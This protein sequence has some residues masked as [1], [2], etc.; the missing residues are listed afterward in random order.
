VHFHAYSY[1]GPGE[2]IKPFDSA[3]Q[4]GGVG[5]ETAVVPPVRTDG[6]LSRPARTIRATWNDPAE[7]V[8][9]LKEQYARIAGSLMYP[10]QQIRAPSVKTMVESALEYLTMGNDVVWAAWLRG[11]AYAHFAVICCPNRTVNGPRCPLG[12]TDTRPPGATRYIG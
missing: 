6:W 3:R 8:A 9:W 5:F 2:A 7:A 10:D 4:V 1:E 12:R 11:G